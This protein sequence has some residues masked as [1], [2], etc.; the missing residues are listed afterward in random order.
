ML[1]ER[2]LFGRQWFV[3]VVVGASVAWGAAAAG[4]CGA[5]PNE[6]DEDDDDGATG[7]SGGGTGGT[8]GVGGGTTTTNTSMCEIDCSTIQTPDCQVSVCNEGRHRGTIGVC[9]V[10]PDED[11]TPCD[12]STFCTVQ[13]ACASGVC[14]GGPANDCGMTPS[15]CMEVYCDE[16]SQSCGEQAAP[17]GAACQ[18][19][20]D[21]CMKGATCTNGLCMGGSQEDCFFTPVPDDCHVAVCNPQTG[22]CE[23]EIGNEGL[24]CIDPNDLCTVGKTCT[25][26]VCQSGAP[27]D[28]SQLT[29]GCFDGVC[30]T[31]TGQCIQQPIQ[32]GGQCA[33]ATDDCNQGICDTQGNCN[34]NPTNEGGN[35]NSDDCV[36]GQT[37]SSGTCQG[38]SQI[39][40]CTNNDLCCPSGCTIQTDSDCL[41][42]ITMAALNTGYTG[43]LGGVAGADADCTTQ[44][45]QNG[46]GGTWRAFLCSGSQNVIDVVPGY[47][48]GFPVKNIN[49][50]TLW[51]NWGE[52]FTTT[53]WIGGGAKMITFSGL[54]VDEPQVVN[55][56]WTDADNWHGCLATGYVAASHCAG[57]TTT[58]G[59]GIGGELDMAQMMIQEVHV[60]TYTSA[61]V[62]VRIGP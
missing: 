11:D 25:N 21:L 13:D 20:N 1:G 22:Q 16:N 40:S 47:L 23:P 27:K 15:Q 61:V 45:A 59:N 38:G 34:G 46:I 31:N 32:P 6:T 56:V 33:E 7:G 37:C 8:G 2:G 52:I 39:T 49:G 36:T 50:V 5:T 19:P 51:N 24:P 48:Q 41:T 29:Q 35:C 14:V 53:S 58:T 54:V 10:V 12:D 62:C 43:N 9:V 60:C 28:C 26:G 3:L 44:A 18:D 55:P 4:G 17:P 30:D 42:E 57:W